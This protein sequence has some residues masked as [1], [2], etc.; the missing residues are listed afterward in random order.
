MYPSL[1]LFKHK[2]FEEPEWAPFA[3]SIFTLQVNLA[4][5]EARS[6]I[7]QQALP[8]I[9]VAIYG[10]R[11]ALL[12]DTSKIIHGQARAAE[13]SAR[14]EVE[15][16]ASRA[17]ITALRAELASQSETVRALRALATGQIPFVGQFRPELQEA[18]AQVSLA[19][20][21]YYD[22]TLC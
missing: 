6:L 14:T 5:D 13:D 9:D 18:V 8:H 16:Q 22:S 3:H 10:T 19:C 11:D 20:F 1:P 12:Y 15:V 17:E 21:M 7:L 4:P 2:M